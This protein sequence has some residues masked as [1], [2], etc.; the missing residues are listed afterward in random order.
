MFKLKKTTVHSAPHIS[1]MMGNSTRQMDSCSIGTLV[2]LI[3]QTMPFV[4]ICGRQTGRNQNP[5][6]SGWT[7][8]SGAPREDIRNNS[9]PF[10][11][12][13]EHNEKDSSL[14]TGAYR[15]PTHTDHYLLFDSHHPQDGS[16]RN[17]TTEHTIYSP[18]HIPKR[19]N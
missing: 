14:Y 2:P 12:R 9:L 1:N 10:L 11:D 13:D 19:K 3:S 18:T 5:G 4:Q 6:S 15:K 16:Y 8:T 17:L 7:K